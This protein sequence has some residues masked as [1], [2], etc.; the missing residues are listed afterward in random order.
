MA[1]IQS[2]SGDTQFF[3]TTE[4]QKQFERSLQGEKVTISQGVKE[5]SILQEAPIRT[6]L[7]ALYNEFKDKLLH[8][9]QPTQRECQRFGCVSEDPVASFRAIRQFWG[10]FP[11]QWVCKRL[12]AP[13]SPPP[14]IWVHS[15]FVEPGSTI[16]Y[17]NPNWVGVNQSSDPQMSWIIEGIYDPGTGDYAFP[18][19]GDDDTLPSFDGNIVVNQYRNPT[20]SAIG[21]IKNNWYNLEIRVDNWFPTNGIGGDLTGG[22]IGVQISN[23]ASVP[24]PPGPPSN[25]NYLNN[26]T[27]Q[28]YNIPTTNTGSSDP[29]TWRKICSLVADLRVY[30]YVPFL[31]S[32]SSYTCGFWLQNYRFTNLYP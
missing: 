15:Y 3:Q 21:Y 14:K 5:A 4:T 20:P 26:T 27:S 8:P 28:S 2:P 9:D 13:P 7:Q 18:F 17:I 1:K 16:Q 30:A 11:D 22:N 24:N 23:G 19:Y 31:P 25:Y 6:D 29:A 32:G 10:L 12:L